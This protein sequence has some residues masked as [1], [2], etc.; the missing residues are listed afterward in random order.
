MSN[1]EIRGIVTELLNREDI[2][3]SISGAVYLLNLDNPEYVLYDEVTVMQA[4]QIINEAVKP[5][6]SALYDLFIQNIILNYKESLLESNYNLELL[7]SYIKD[8][9]DISKTLSDSSLNPVGSH[10][11]HGSEPDLE[12][13]EDTTIVYAYDSRV[14]DNIDEKIYYQSL[15]E[16]IPETLNSL[17]DPYH[18]P[19]AGGSEL[20]DVEDPPLPVNTTREE[21]QETN[22]ATQSLIRLRSGNKNKKSKKKKKKSTKKKKKKSK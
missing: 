2:E 18:N 22:I 1:I 15:A 13:V 9:S 21:S 12:L 5:E 3:S 4:V 7:H 10:I 16:K 14:D 8:V 11:A 17:Y 6:N 20:I 19:I